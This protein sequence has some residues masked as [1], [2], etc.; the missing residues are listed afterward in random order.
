MDDSAITCDG[1]IEPYDEEINF[2]EKKATAK[3]KISYIL[4]NYY[5]II[6]SC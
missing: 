4:I 6:D 5:S 2:N 1:I 3:C